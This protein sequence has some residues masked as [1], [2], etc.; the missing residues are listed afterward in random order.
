LGGKTPLTVATQRSS[1]A[2]V[3]ATRIGAPAPS[4]E[5]LLKRV[6][7]PWA[8]W[9]LQPENTQLEPY[10]PRTLNTLQEVLLRRYVATVS[11]L[12][13][14]SPANT[15]PRALEQNTASKASLWELGNTVV[16]TAAA[17]ARDRYDRLV[18][19]GGAMASLI[20]QAG[21]AV[22][23]PDAAAL[24]G[25]I[26]RQAVEKRRERGTLLAVMLNG[27][28]RYPVFQ[29]EHAEVLAG[30]PTVLKSFTVRDGW[31]QPSVLMSLHDA[32]N[33]RTVVAA[34]KDG[35]STLRSPSRRASA[36][37][38]GRK[39]ASPPSCC[40]HLSARQI[41]PISGSVLRHQP[42]PRSES[43]TQLCGSSVKAVAARGPKQLSQR[44]NS[45]NLRLCSWPWLSLWCGSLV[46]APGSM[47]RSGSLSS[48]LRRAPFWKVNVRAS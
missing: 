38:E 39:C 36:T 40:G 28:C 5:D 32:L 9:M 23:A 30:L 19:L 26:T 7:E 8:E 11:D 46:I 17:S 14:H 48:F 43:E 10:P 37:P 6:A 18:D 41:A 21:G 45:L 15:A 2:T 13:K 31:T 47:P 12:V 25:G 16:D 42:Y 29:F 22:T 33:G 44:T 34:L 1:P 4:R 27:E 20:A 3:A 35:E 24:L